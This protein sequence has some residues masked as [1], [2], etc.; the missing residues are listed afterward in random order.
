MA[1]AIGATED[2]TTG[3]ETPPGTCHDLRTYVLASAS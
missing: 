3:V 1:D 2:A